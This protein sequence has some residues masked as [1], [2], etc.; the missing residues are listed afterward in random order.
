MTRRTRNGAARR[1][2]S[3]PR[4][5]ASRSIGLVVEGRTEGIAFRRLPELFP[6]C[7]PVDRPAV[8]D[9][10]GDIS[11]TN[12]AKRVAREVAF[13][14]PDNYKVIV[15]LDL[16]CRQSSASDFARDVATAL[17]DTLP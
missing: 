14:Q 13:L 9:G 10:I 4:R 17:T 11:A 5:P 1:R 15:C 8:V 6:G 7:P 3:R 12:V 2:G 16:E